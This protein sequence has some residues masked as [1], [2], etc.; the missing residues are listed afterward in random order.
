MNA[1]YSTA[2]KWSWMIIPGC[3]L[4]C[5]GFIALYCYTSKPL[6]DK[7][8]RDGSPVTLVREMQHVLPTPDNTGDFASRSTVANRDTDLPESTKQQLAALGFGAENGNPV[9]VGVNVGVATNAGSKRK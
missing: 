1:Q 5:V 7:H 2:P 9:S 3:V 8:P 6:P 4:F